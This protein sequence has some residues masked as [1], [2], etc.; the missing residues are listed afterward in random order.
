MHHLEQLIDIP[1]GGALGREL[2]DVA[3]YGREG[4]TGARDRQTMG[5]L[6]KKEPVM[7][8][9]TIPYYLQLMASG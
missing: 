7:L 4:Q 1:V 3:V 5:L 2:S 9:V 6:H 8:L